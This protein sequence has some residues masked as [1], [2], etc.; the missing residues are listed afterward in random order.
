MFTEAIKI[1]RNVDLT[2][3]GRLPTGLAVGT[4]GLCNVEMA[5]GKLVTFKMRPATVLPVC[6]RRILSK[7]TTARKLVAIYTEHK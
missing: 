7:G 1:R 3:D 6:F 4:G 5:S 2:R